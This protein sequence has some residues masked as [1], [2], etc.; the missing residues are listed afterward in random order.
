MTMKTKMKMKQAF[1]KLLEI[2]LAINAFLKKPDSEFNEGF[3]ELL[4]AKD[5]LI[6]TLK[7]FKERPGF[8][9]ALDKILDLEKENLNL[10]VARKEQVKEETHRLKA[11]AKVISS[12]KYQKDQEPRLFDDSL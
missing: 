3:G 12:Y 8:K 7:S 5:S 11:H 4:K 6:E 2:N 10:I 9:E 1:E